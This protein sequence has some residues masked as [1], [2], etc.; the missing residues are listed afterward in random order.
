MHELTVGGRASPDCFNHMTKCTQSANRKSALRPLITHASQHAPH[1]C[2]HGTLITRAFPPIPLRTVHW[3]CSHSPH[4]KP[5]SLPPSLAIISRNVR[6]ANARARILLIALRIFLCVH[7]H[8]R[9]GARQ[10]AAGGGC[11]LCAKR[12]DKYVWP[13]VCGRARKSR[14]QACPLIRHRNRKRKCSADR[15]LAARS[16]YGVAE[17]KHRVQWTAN[18]G[19]RVFFICAVVNS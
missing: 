13:S 15:E 1:R 9:V 14:V 4:P 16:V 19:G 6:I 3:R 7:E 10:D 5:T 17:H 2:H 18:A 8:V 11:S 12:T